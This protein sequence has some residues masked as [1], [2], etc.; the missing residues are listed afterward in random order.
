MK[1]I[2]LLSLSILL[3]LAFYGCSENRKQY[4]VKI[5]VSGTG[6]KEITGSITAE[7]V[8]KA[9]FMSKPF[10]LDV[11]GSVELKAGGGSSYDVRVMPWPKENMQLKIYVDGKELDAGK[12]V[13]AFTGPTV[14]SAMFEI[15][16][17]A[18]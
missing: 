6:Q 16:E 3:L 13:G 14:Y 17:E 1:K 15:K 9:E 5:E 11:P 10:K 2:L 8:K 12:C 7:S 18:K 4:T